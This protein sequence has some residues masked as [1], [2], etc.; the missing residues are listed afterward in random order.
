MNL[1]LSKCASNILKTVALMVFVPA[2]YIAV[3]FHVVFL[4]AYHALIALVIGLVGC[5]LSLYILAVYLKLKLI[6]NHT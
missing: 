5:V 3:A 2:Y 4:V 6:G 1:D